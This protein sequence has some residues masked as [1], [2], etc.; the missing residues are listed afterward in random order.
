MGRARRARSARSRAT[1]RIALVGKYVQ[2]QDAYLS[3]VEALRHAGTH[4]GK[5]VE[6]VW[7]DAESLRPEEITTQLAWADGILVPG[8][9]GDTRDR[10]KDPGG[11]VR[12]RA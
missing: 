2:L 9:F 5:D 7:V 6:I 11:A 4:H 10:G 1:I 12:P 8:G 3:V